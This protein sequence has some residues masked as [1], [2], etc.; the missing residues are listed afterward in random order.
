M[1]RGVFVRDKLSSLVGLRRLV[2]SDTHT[3][4]HTH[5]ERRFWLYSYT[6][7][8]SRL[9][10][11]LSGI[12]CIYIQRLNL[13][14][15]GDEKPPCHCYKYKEH[16]DLSLGDINT[17]DAYMCTFIFIQFWLFVITDSDKFTCV[18]QSYNYNNVIIIIISLDVLYFPYSRFSALESCFVTS[19]SIGWTRN[20]GGSMKILHILHVVL[21]MLDP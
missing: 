5:T 16:F 10:A 12:S 6:S 13:C 14:V 1:S 9:S 17:F 20:A 19:I 4:T 21:K 2:L 18:N 7:S 15:S 3:H 8:R 11:L